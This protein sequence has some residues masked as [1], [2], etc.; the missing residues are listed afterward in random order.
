MS[1]SSTEMLPPSLRGKLIGSEKTTGAVV[2]LGAAGL[3]GYG[4]FLALPIIA[5]MMVSLFTIS[6]CAL[7]VTVIAFVA[8]NKGTRSAFGLGYA[9]LIRKLHNMIVQ[10]APFDI[11]NYLIGCMQQRIADGQERLAHLRAANNRIG[12]QIAK[13][14]QTIQQRVGLAKAAEQLGQTA[15]KEAQLRMLG[16]TDAANQRLKAQLDMQR[17]L[18]EMMQ[19]GIENAKI[20]VEEQQE[21]VKLAIE[22]N[23]ALTEG[24]EAAGDVLAA[25]NGD[26]EKKALFD[27][28][29]DVIARDSALKLGQI[30]QMMLDLK[31]I[32]NDIELG[33]IVDTAQGQK[34]LESFGQRIDQIALAPVKKIPV[35]ESVKTQ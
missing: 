17:Q 25:I 21:A 9:V 26:P 33:K 31:P 11:V 16:S 28:A 13:N 3:L 4:L 18:T 6:A 10:R 19:N 23:S 8:L 35:I 32:L 20:R 29:M 7:G 1:D 27:E 15:R 22:T 30:D 2:G 12:A 14:E 24:K 34:V 5:Q